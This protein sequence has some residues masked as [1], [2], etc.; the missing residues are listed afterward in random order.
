MTT[1]NGQEIPEGS[2]V[3][4]TTTT[5]EAVVIKAADIAALETK[6]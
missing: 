1:V 2:T 3:I 6:E 4:I 5:A